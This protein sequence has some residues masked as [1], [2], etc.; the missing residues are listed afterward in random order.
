MR[1]CLF[2][3]AICH[4]RKG[5]LRRVLRILKKASKEFFIPV[6][7][8][9]SN[10]SGRTKKKVRN[11]ILVHKKQTEYSSIL[12]TSKFTQFTAA[13]LTLEVSENFQ[14][15]LMAFF[16]SL[17][18]QTDFLDVNICFKSDNFVDN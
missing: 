15:L 13:Q 7:M 11:T 2:S 9:L 1:L 5:V 8:L 3:T 17:Q 14:E 18:Y 16:L 4:Q 6:R 12:K 10:P